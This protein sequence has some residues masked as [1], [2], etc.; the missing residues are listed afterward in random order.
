MPSL[1]IRALA[2]GFTALATAAVLTGCAASRLSPQAPAGVALAGDWKLDPARSDHLGRAVAELSAQAR[3]HARDLRRKLAAR[4]EQEQEQDQEGGGARGRRG[5]AD[6]GQSS[7]ATAGAAAIGLGPRVSA[8]DELMASVPQG[9]YLRI[10]AGAGAFTVTSGASAEQ[11]TP[12]LESDV[13]AQQGD[14]RQIS[15]WKGTDYVIDTQPQWGPEIV[16]TYGLTKEGRLRLT[17]Q[18]TGAGIRFL[19]TRVYD[20]TTRAPALAPPTNN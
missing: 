10:S 9:D 6:E 15:G 17:V 19:F 5:E 18:L 16:Q 3:K 13:S 11:Y 8:A 7:A 4:M 12:G 1:R 14:A 2:L 20:R